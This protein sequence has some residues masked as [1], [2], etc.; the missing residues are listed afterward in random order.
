MWASKKPHFFPTIWMANEYAQLT[1]CRGNLFSL[2]CFFYVFFFNYRFQTL[3]YPEEICYSVLICKMFYF[4]S[5]QKNTFRQSSPRT[6]DEGNPLYTMISVG[7]SSSH[8]VRGPMDD[9]ATGYLSMKIWGNCQLHVFGCYADS[10]A[11]DED[12]ISSV[13]GG[14][15]VSLHEKLQGLETCPAN[16]GDVDEAWSKW[17]NL[18]TLMIWLDIE[19]LLLASWKRF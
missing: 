9:V 18:M 19:S 1:P 15:M 11:W 8:V 2:Q 6:S 16:V 17:K 12:L 3:I 14:Y 5:D 10:V 4:S 7:L 13:F